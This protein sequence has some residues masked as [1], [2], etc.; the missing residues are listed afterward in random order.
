MNRHIR[1]RR[2]QVKRFE[3]RQ[4]EELI[5][6]FDRLNRIVLEEKGNQTGHRLK[7][8]CIERSNLIVGE[9]QNLQMVGRIFA[10][11]RN[12]CQLCLTQIEMNQMFQ[13]GEIDDGRI[14][15]RSTQIENLNVHISAQL[16]WPSGEGVSGH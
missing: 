9:I 3:M 12:P 2:D 11:L 6:M 8:Q 14:E 15:V 5:E 13:T 10:E 4:V 16:Q 7:I 1:I